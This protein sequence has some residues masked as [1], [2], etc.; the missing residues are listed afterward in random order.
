M[1]HDRLPQIPPIIEPLS[2][3]LERPLWS[4]MIPTFNC[5]KYLKGTLESVLMQAKD[6][7]DMQIAVIDD[8]STDEDIEAMVINI[9]KGRI[10]FYKQEQNVGSLRNFESCIKRSR[11]QLIHILHG[12]DQ[13]KSGFYTEIEG[14]FKQY[15]TIGAAFANLSLI[16]ENGIVIKHNKHIQN[17]AGIIQDWLLKISKRQRL[18]TCSIVVKRSVY[19]ELGGFYKVHYGEDWEMWVRIAAKFPVAYS[20]KNLALY[21]VHNNNI[22]TRYMSTGQ[23]IKDMKTVID[24]IQDYLPLEKRKEIKKM[25]RRNC[26]IHFSENAQNIYKNERNKKVAILQAKESM[27]L[28]FNIKTFQLYLRVYLKALINY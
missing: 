19:E 23:N 21:R 1:L 20:P 4:V 5:S 25:A 3:S 6:I 14:I 12:D 24:T 15:A 10:E 7:P 2:D 26:A 27:R 8:Y 13:V 9:G 28:H 16:D 18:Q 11:G 17:Y 22:S